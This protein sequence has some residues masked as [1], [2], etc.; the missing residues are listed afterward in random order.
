MNIEI[1]CEGERLET[2]P[3]D[4]PPRR[5][6]YVLV[7][8][9]LFVVNA[10]CHNTDSTGATQYEVYVTQAPSPAPASRVV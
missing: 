6:D 2:Q 8:G 3:F 10:I 7:S 5:D 9:Q 4:I 1:Y